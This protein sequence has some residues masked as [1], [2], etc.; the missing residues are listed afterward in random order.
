[1]DIGAMINKTASWLEG[2]G[3]ESDIV[4]SSRIRLARNVVNHPF[5]QWAEQDEQKKLYELIQK[6]LSKMEISKKME[7]LP[8]HNFSQLDRQILL[9]RHLVSKEHIE[10]DGFAGIALTQD[11]QISVMIN[12]EDHLRLQVIF[13][14]FQLDKAWKV[15]NDLDDEL[16]THLEYAFNAPLGFLT[17]CPTN[18]GTGLRASAMIHLPGLVLLKQID[19]VLRAVTKLGLT[20]RGWYGEGSQASGN[21]FQISNQI[22][23]GKKESDIILNLEQV[24]RQILDHER[25]ARKTLLKKSPY[26][27]K[28]RIGRA[29]GIMKHA[30]MISSSETLEQLSTMRAGIETGILKSVDIRVINELFLLT[31]PAHI[32]KIAGRKLSNKD[33]DYKRAALIRQ[34][35]RSESFE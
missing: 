28:D 8:I 12:E 23:L 3:P 17:A 18:V 25:N 14:G 22:T 1:M 4:I 21:L 35:L 16:S 11:E 9:E 20:V 7:I 26:Q 27:V 30:Y 24:I 15:M 32:Q 19:Q 31:Q 10:S 34:M 13:S 29:F 5:P 6:S 2:S 33:R